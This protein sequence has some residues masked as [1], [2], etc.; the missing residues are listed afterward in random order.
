[1]VLSLFYEDSDV[2][3]QLRA[4]FSVDEQW[5][6]DFWSLLA[7]V[8]DY[9]DENF[10]LKIKDKTFKIHKVHGSVVEVT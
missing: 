3:N 8:T 7:L 5:E 6:I 1:M 9:D 10:M 2:V 4:F